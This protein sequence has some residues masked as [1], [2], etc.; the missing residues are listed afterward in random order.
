MPVHCISLRGMFGAS[1]RAC[2]LLYQIT[3]TPCN[4]LRVIIRYGKDD[5]KATY[6]D[7]TPFARRRIWAGHLIQVSPVDVR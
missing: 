6:F 5:F 3:T 4:E 1:Y 2:G 7:S